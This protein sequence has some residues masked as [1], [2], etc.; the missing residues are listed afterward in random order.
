MTD[1]V[2]LDQLVEQIDAV[3]PQTQCTRCNYPS[4]RAYAI[5][6]AE[7]SANI[8]QCPPGGEFGIERLAAL[9]NKPILP[10]NPAN[11]EILP[12]RLAVIDEEVCIGCTLCI[13]AC[14]VDAIIG[15]NKMLHTI[16][17]DDC[18]GCDL[19][20]PA[21][22]VDCIS[23]IIDPQQEWTKQRRDK[24]QSSFIKKNQR[25][26]KNNKDRNARLLARTQAL[27]NN[28]SKEFINQILSDA[29]QK[30]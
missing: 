19:C 13:K 15:S 17:A 4:C 12:R 1:K 8:N 26:E 10:L 6:L 18:T 27:K 11:G 20:I 5:A 21:C 9:L 29:K 24:A 23:V 22:P 16:V 14:P 28:D 2:A 30:D 3:L 7:N 25:Q